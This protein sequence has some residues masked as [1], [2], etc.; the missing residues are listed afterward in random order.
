MIHDVPRTVKPGVGVAATIEASPNDRELRCEAV[1]RDF[2]DGE[3]VLRVLHQITL[4]IESGTLTML[5]GPSGCGK[6]TLV[7]ILAGILT[8]SAGHVSLFGQRLSQLSPSALAAFRLREVG[9]VFQQY[10]LL[11]TLT[12]AENAGITLTAQGHSRSAA[13]R[14]GAALLAKLDMGEQVDRLPS[15][16]SGGQQQRVAIARALAH[17]PRLVICDEPT[18]ALDANSGRKAM[19]MFRSV[20]MKPERAVIIVSH[21]ERIYHY[22]DRIIE[23]EDGRIRRDYA[24]DRSPPPRAGEKS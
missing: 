9:F 18:A 23:M 10:N 17:A 3:Q 13:R 1:D 24:P 8:P 14:A 6:T 22:G 15:Q 11:P 12:A 5:V 19:E 20:M 2:S 21:D 4:A 7:S 16:L